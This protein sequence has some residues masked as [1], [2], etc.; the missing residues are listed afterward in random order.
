[1]SLY[2]IMK[3]CDLKTNTGGKKTSGIPPE[4]ISEKINAVFHV[5]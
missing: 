3:T 1:M 2:Y 5:G 4:C